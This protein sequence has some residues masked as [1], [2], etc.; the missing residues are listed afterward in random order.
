M[1]LQ[2]QLY[3]GFNLDG[4]GEP[5]ILKEKLHIKQNDTELQAF[6]FEQLCHKIK[7][8]TL[9]LIDTI[10]VKLNKKFPRF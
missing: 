8:Y 1:K 10:G 9:P 5:G 7:G 2:T 6:D 4:S 3:P